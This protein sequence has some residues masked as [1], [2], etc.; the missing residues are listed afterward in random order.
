MKP[1]VK[2]STKALVPAACCFVTFA[3][4]AWQIAFATG[5]LRLDQPF[6]VEIVVHGPDGKVIPAVGRAPK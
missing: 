5:E 4:I 1:I 6:N 3:Y 2:S